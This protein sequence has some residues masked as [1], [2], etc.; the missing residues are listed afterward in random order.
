MLPDTRSTGLRY[1]SQELGKL[2]S[3]RPLTVYSYCDNYVSNTAVQAV[4]TDCNMPCNG[5]ASE[6]CGAGQ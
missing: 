6:F 5:N 4:S 2:L 3:R 1:T